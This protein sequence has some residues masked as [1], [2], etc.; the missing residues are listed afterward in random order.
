MPRFW[1]AAVV[2]IASSIAGWQSLVLFFSIRHSK[3]CSRNQ[4]HCILDS[5]VGGAFRDRVCRYTLHEAHCTALVGRVVNMRRT[6]WTTT[7]SKHDSKPDWWQNV[8]VVQRDWCFS[9][10]ISNVN[11]SVYF[12]HRNSKPGTNSNQIHPMPCATVNAECCL[13]HM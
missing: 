3:V 9:H 6:E 8:F 4:A 11:C 13:R 5:E 12:R 1:F 10:T 2:R 7:V